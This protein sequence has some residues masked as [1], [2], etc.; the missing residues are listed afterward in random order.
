MKK[1]RRRWWLAVAGA[2]A[3]LALWL[4]MREQPQPPGQRESVPD[5]PSVGGRGHSRR[6]RSSD[7]RGAEAPAANKRPVAPLIDEVLIEKPE[8]CVGEENLVTVKAHTPDH[9]DDAYLRYMIGGKIGSSVVVRA[10]PEIGARNDMKVVVFGRN[11]AS[12]TVDVPPF[13][14]K[15]CNVDHKLLVSFRLLANRASAFELAARIDRVG[16]SEAFQPVQ[17][18]WS[19][20]DGTT[21][22]TSVPV[23]TH[24]FSRRPQE[25]MT[26]TFLITCAAVSRSGQKIAGRTALALNN[27]AFES[28]AQKGVVK[29]LAEADPLFPVMGS[30]GRVSERIRLW[31]PYSGSVR[32]DR[33]RRTKL[34]MGTAVAPPESL[35]A[36]LL[37]IA[38]IEPGQTVTSK[39]FTLDTNADPAVYSIEYLIEGTTEDGWPA[40]G[41][42][43]LMRPPRPP[44]RQNNAPVV[45]P[46]LKAKILRARE[47]LG[48][49]F[50]TDQDIWRLEREGRLDHLEVDPLAVPP[51]GVPASTRPSPRPPIPGPP[52]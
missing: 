2:V 37:G 48:K 12:T 26:S 43:A 3:A 22:Q 35:P 15:D 9:A 30:D 33:L 20:G 11:G 25:T 44:T 24:D 1:P 14:V 36:S 23:E 10:T 17:Y 8:V 50:V 7:P 52:R 34:V 5:Q 18:L 42:F 16:S 40:T 31:H 29:I 45:D 38:R 28:F 4:L 19:F 47:L 46:T 32:I 13:V 27:L 21:S 39:V 6:D 41:N 51:A 49:E